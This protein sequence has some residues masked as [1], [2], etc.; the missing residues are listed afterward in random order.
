MPPRPPPPTLQVGGTKLNETSSRSHTIFRV[1]VE[2]REREGEAGAARVSMLSFVDLAGSE[3]L[4]KSGAE[5]ARAEETAQINLS[6][7]ALGNVISKLAEAGG[8]G[9]GGGEGGEFIPYRNSKLTRILQPSLGG[10]ARTVIVATVRPA[11]EHA[12]ETLH[13]LR[14]ASRAT[15]VR[16]PEENEDARAARVALGAV[17]W[18]VPDE[19]SLQLR[20]RTRSAGGALTTRPV[21]RVGI[22]AGCLFFSFEE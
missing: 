10:N 22:G 11:V 18:A 17:G 12:E 7:L 6:L 14:F 19:R 5:G 1:M 20:R 16:M 9:G 2:A 15:K 3:R 13:T 21:R 4:S 8:G